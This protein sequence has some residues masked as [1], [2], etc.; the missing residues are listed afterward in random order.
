LSVAS[1]SWAACPEGTKQTYKGC[2]AIDDE[3]TQGGEATKSAEERYFIDQP[4]LN[5][6]YQIHLIYL[7]A[8]DS[9]DREWD[10][11]GNINLIIEKMN[12][13]MFVATRKN[14]YSGGE[15]KRYKFDYR[16]DGKL[17]ITFIRFDKKNSD[18]PKH[19]NAYIKKYL[20]KRGFNHPKKIYY[21]FAEIKT[22]DG[23]EAGVGMGTIFLGSKFN[24]TRP[25]TG[26]VRRNF[27]HIS[28]HE[29]LHA[30]GVGFPC[31]PEVSRA[32]LKKNDKHMLGGGI[33]LN[34]NIYGHN[35]QGCPQLKNSVFL[36]PTS[37]DSYDPYKVLCS[38]KIGGFNHPKMR[39]IETDID[40]YEGPRC[41]WPIR[42]T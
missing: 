26:D 24:N 35:V 40:Q 22:Y 18:L 39:L 38:R 42:G 9:K 16:L 6:D 13:Q 3:V 25:I 15:G 17:D 11:N 8:K 21:S 7:L 32:H 1:V 10:I 2:E 34:A 28:L 5:D 30:Q 20:W 36:T 12:Q 23:G 14:K 4:D 41:K 37:E 31:M 29:I 19:P 27:T 33:W